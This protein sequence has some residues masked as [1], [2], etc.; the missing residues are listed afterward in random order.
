MSFSIDFP[1]ARLE[2]RK[3]AEKEPRGRAARRWKAA[4][5]PSFSVW[6]GVRGGNLSGLVNGRVLR[7]RGAQPFALIGGSSALRLEGRRGAIA[8]LDF[9]SIVV[10]RSPSR[11]PSPPVA[12]S[13]VA[14]VF[15]FRSC[16]STT[17]GGVVMMG[18]RGGL[19]ER[20]EAKLLK[21]LSYSL[22]KLIYRSREGHVRTY[23]T[24]PRKFRVKFLFFVVV[25]E[26]PTAR[27]ELI[28]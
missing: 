13:Y 11:W 3:E 5:A 4:K 14:T 8:N 15:R 6:L 1:I 25:K 23:V 7:H 22:L 9:E 18:R 21:S 26:S 12:P 20:S 27:M 28:S 24:A 10:V 19:V 16:A 2:G 17:S